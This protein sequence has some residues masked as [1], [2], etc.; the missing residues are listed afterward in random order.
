MS[1]LM[2]KITQKPHF[3]NLSSVGCFLQKVKFD[4]DLLRIES[5]ALDLRFFS[6]V[7]L[8]DTFDGKS[9]PYDGVSYR[10][11]LYGNQIVWERFKQYDH[12]S[13]VGTQEGGDE[14]FYM[15]YRVAEVYK[16]VLLIA[17]RKF[18]K[19]NQDH[20]RADLVACYAEEL[21]ILQQHPQYREL[22][23]DFGLKLFPQRGKNKGWFR[24]TVSKHHP[25][26]AR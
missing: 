7:L 20:E 19:G 8:T 10:A 5:N 26:T 6:M 3:N 4:Q 11:V 23:R 21:A 22:V 24:V 15:M 13:G 12:G 1:A 18:R 16:K 17:G 2:A 9:A 14:R 25:V